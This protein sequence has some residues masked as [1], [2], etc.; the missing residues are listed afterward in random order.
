MPRLQVLIEHYC[1]QDPPFIAELG[2]KSEWEMFRVLLSTTYSSWSH[3][4]VMKMVVGNRTVR[5]LY[6]NLCKLA[7]I[8]LIL[9]LSTADCERAFSTMKRVKTTLRNRLCTKTLDSLMRIR[10]EGPDMSSFDFELALNSWAK[11]CNRRI[12]V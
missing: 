4:Q 5:T 1:Q 7:Q 3:Y 11:L 6:P 2:L 9:P 10:V 8:C 12:K